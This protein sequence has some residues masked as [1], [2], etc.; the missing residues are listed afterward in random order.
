MIPHPTTI[1]AIADLRRRDL[2]ADAERERRADIAAALDL[3]WRPL[4]VP[5]LT[6]MAL[7]LGLRR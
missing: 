3:Q 7:L 6:L 2:L 4:P 1:H 5:V